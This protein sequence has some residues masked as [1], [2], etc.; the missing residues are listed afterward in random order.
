M[1]I[2]SFMPL[3]FITMHRY[4]RVAT[5][6]LPR[7]P[8]PAAHCCRMK[9]VRCSTVDVP[10][11]RQRRGRG[12]RQ[13]GGRGPAPAGR[14][15][16]LRCAARPTIG[17]TGSLAAAAAAAHTTRRDGYQLDHHVDHNAPRGESDPTPNPQPPLS[18]HEQHCVRWED[19]IG[20]RRFGRRAAH[21]GG[22]LHP[23]PPTVVCSSRAALVA[24]CRRAASRLH[25]ARRHAGRRSSQKTRPPPTPPSSPPSPGRR[26][27]QSGS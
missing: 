8:Q 16:S 26:P 1:Y 18:V 21:R 12:G 13:S 2:V 4:P 25:V 27:K 9:R 19:G 14:P 22:T 24:A 7:C 5:T 15:H 6:L 17:A 11:G 3:N 23:S 20:R 10:R